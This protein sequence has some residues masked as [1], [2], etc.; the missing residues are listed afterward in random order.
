MAFFSQAIHF[1][2]FILDDN[3]HILENKHIEFTLNNVLWFWTNSKTPIAYNIWQLVG[4]VGGIDNPVL[5]RIVNILFHSLNII[6]IYRIIQRLSSNSKSKDL[7][8]FFCAGCFALHPV[9]V[10]SVVWISSLRGLSSAFFTFLAILLSIEYKTGT[11]KLVTL[12][13]LFIAGLVAKPT[14]FL[15]PLIFLSIDIHFHKLSFKRA[16]RQNITVLLLLC[17]G[18]FYFSG[19]VLISMTDGGVLDQARLFLFSLQIY[20]KKFFFLLPFGYEISGLKEVYTYQF[21]ALDYAAALSFM[22]FIGAGAYFSKK[23]KI[24]YSLPLIIF[25]CFYFPISGTLSFHYQI[26][27]AVAE[28]YFYLPIIGFAW[29]LAIIICHLFSKFSKGIF[30]FILLCSS[31]VTFRLV[32]DWSSF[33]IFKTD[34]TKSSFFYNMLL[35]QY[36]LDKWE[37]EKAEMSFLRA[38]EENPNFLDSNVGL[39]SVY[40]KQGNFEK[41][42]ALRDSLGNKLFED[43]NL[44]SN[45]I[46]ALVEKRRF[47]QAKS[48]L[49][50]NLGQYLYSK[51]YIEIYINLL[52]SEEDFLTHVTSSNIARS[53]TQKKELEIRLSKIELKIKELSGLL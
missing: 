26:V 2:F 12:A 28:R 47:D 25:L 11:K 1:P 4:Y 24:G 8:A 5:F 10:E 3:F 32:G 51:Q 39:M 53:S 43:W 44:L 50:N 30:I 22:I 6:L 7:I 29:F 40:L 20:F 35:G 21:S 38:K 31:I 34:R 52:R 19:D 13:L 42:Q 36:Q 14:M 16:F 33:D 9:Q 41:V 37:L 48:L 18:V 46:S 15:L 27:S 49:E 23:E 45:Y 17:L